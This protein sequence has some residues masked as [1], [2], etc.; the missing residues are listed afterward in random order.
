MNS[1]D[2]FRP[3]LKNHP[4]SDKHINIGKAKDESFCNADYARIVR[5]SNGGYASKMIVNAFHFL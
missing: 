2:P 4:L 1:S 3:H 5:A